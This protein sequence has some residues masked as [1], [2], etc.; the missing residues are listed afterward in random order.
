MKRKN[1]H[2]NDIKNYELESWKNSTVSKIYS[3]L[4][5][6]LFHRTSINGYRGIKRSGKILPNSGQFPY[7]YPQSKYYFGTS[8]SYVS[9]FDFSS[10][11]Y[12]ELITIHHTWGGF[13][14]DQKPVTIVL[15]LNKRLLSGK[16]I[17]NS[18]AKLDNPENKGYIPYV[19]AWYPEAIPFS[20]IIGLIIS[21][22]V[23]IDKPP[24]FQ[25][26]PVK[27]IDEFE[28]KINE[29]NNQYSA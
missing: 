14:Y 8:K 3:F 24:F 7:T 22:E 23:E 27:E 4:K 26:F 13:F 21:F 10:A 15:R 25:E 5:N 9:L 18:I 17:P 19:E 2:D 1:D 11:Q 12:R 16:L 29:I 6:G 20:A 28:N